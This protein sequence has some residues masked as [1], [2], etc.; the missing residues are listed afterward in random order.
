MFATHGAAHVCVPLVLEGIV[1][2]RN[3]PLLGMARPGACWAAPCRILEAFRHRVNG[4]SP[5]RLTAVDMAAGGLGT[6][7]P[8]HRA[9]RPVAPSSAKLLLTVAQLTYGPPDGSYR[10]S[11][12][13]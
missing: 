10:E 8:K 1:D 5:V 9:C 7:K 2:R 13:T 11:T 6:T 3:P 4:T 12:T